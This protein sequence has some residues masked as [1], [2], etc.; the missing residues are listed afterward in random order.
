MRPLLQTALS[1]IKERG[2]FEQALQKAKPPP[3]SDIDDSIET[4]NYLSMT[5][6]ASLSGASM[7]L[8]FDGGKRSKYID[9]SESFDSESEDISIDDI[10]D[11]ILDDTPKPASKREKRTSTPATPRSTT[12]VKNHQ[13]ERTADDIDWDSLVGGLITDDTKIRPANEKPPSAA[14]VTLLDSKDEID[15]KSL[16]DELKN[17]PEASLPATSA[18]T[19][20]PEPSV[21]SGQAPIDWQSMIKDL[22]TELESITEP[23]EATPTTATK[24]EPQVIIA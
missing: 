19:S 3:E 4:D 24:T 1:L 7:D 17:E 23:T 21:S 8:D 22:E 11:D 10:L 14:D 16:E 2:G 20:E 9:E 13:S 18:P 6:D 15:W 12:S 5:S